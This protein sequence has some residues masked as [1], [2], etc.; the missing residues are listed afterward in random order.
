M[1][2]DPSEF[3]SSGIPFFDQLAKAM[4]S[5][6]PVQW[7]I[8][9][10]L[11]IATAT[12]SLT[13]PNV[14]PTARIAIH[15]LSAVADMHVRDVTGLTTSG[16]TQP[17]K[18]DVVIR[19]TWVHQTLETFK[20]YFSDFRGNF[21]NQSDESSNELDS[22]GMD[23]MMANLTKMM[24]PAML[25][26]SVGTMIGQL[27]LRAFGQ[28]DLPLPREPNSQLLFVARNID[29]FAKDWSIDAE[30]MRMWLLI[31]ELTYH[32]L[33]RIGF[34][35]DAVI[36]LVKKHVA[37]FRPNPN[38]LGQRLTKIEVTNTD[39]AAMMQKLLGDPSL[40]LGAER[41]AE[42]QALAPQLDA[43][44]CAIVCY[45]DF[46]VDTVARRILGNGAQISEAVRRRRV[47]SSSQDQY[48]EQ[49]L[50]LNLTNDQVDRGERFIAGV[51]ERTG[52][53]GLANLWTRA[54]N[55]PTPNEI[56]APGL[57][58]ERIKL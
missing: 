11:A 8:A 37:G 48:V 42:Q 51:I 49:L 41:S 35:R 20:F 9:G 1:P 2:Q 13:E 28:Y 32:S 25:G 55:L 30:D 10:Q 7:E 45:V 19:S 6:G 36:D 57:W 16:S 5:A 52:E 39:P 54:G 40:F 58:I 23:A 15:Q 29:A 3:S 46:V 47:E 4:S 50:G 22:G 44:I 26:M 27:S 43:M 24:T 38:A 31:Q 33:F 34:V 17:P 21:A 18:I 12:N 14:E 56:S 53:S